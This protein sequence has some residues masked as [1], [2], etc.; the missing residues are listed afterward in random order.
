[1]TRMDTA[2]EGA[3]RWTVPPTGM[4]A[5]R[6]NADQSLETALVDMAGL[7]V[8]VNTAS[9]A[10]HSVISAFYRPP[11]GFNA[12]PDWTVSATATAVPVGVPVNSHGVGYKAVLD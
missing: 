1:M 12:E 5:Y 11:L 10:V 8:A 3:E 6:Q 7:V 4:G 9:A 2:S